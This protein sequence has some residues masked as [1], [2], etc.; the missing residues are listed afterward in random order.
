MELF[1]PSITSCTVYRRINENNVVIR[2][3]K[4]S[5]YRE[6]MV[7]IWEYVAEG[8][9]KKSTGPGRFSQYKYETKIRNLI[10]NRFWIILRGEEKLNRL[11]NAVAQVCTPS[12]NWRWSCSESTDHIQTLKRSHPAFEGV[13]INSKWISDVLVGFSW[14][15][16]FPPSFGQKT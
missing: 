9:Y 2:Q 12:P 10:E 11:N 13:A 16:F 1:N 5:C 8:G 6:K 14:H 7:T 15:A 4:L 3:Y